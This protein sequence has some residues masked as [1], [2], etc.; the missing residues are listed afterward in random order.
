MNR[1]VKYTDEKMKELAKKIGV[2]AIKYYLAKY[3]TDRIITLKWEDVLN[4]EGNSCPYIQYAY[5]RGRAIKFQDHGF[6]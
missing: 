4:F 5:V 6:S 2:G 1:G 3:K